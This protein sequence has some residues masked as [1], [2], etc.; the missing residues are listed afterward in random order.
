MM[1]DILAALDWFFQLA[2]VVGIVGLM[3]WH[4]YVAFQGPREH[5]ANASGLLYDEY[6][7]NI[8][9]QLYLDM[10]ATKTP[11]NAIHYEQFKELGTF[12]MAN[13]R[14]GGMSLRQF[15]YE[16]TPRLQALL[17]QI[18]GPLFIEDQLK[19]E[20]LLDRFLAT[21]RQLLNKKLHETAITMS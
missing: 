16:H 19:Y 21:Q 10:Q 7:S 13:V 9:L 12:V 1:D 15:D 6:F 2:I 11:L 3:G 18:I 5:M 8:L 20:Y 17:E 14:V 4:M